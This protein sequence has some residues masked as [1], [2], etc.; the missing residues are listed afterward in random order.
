M[1]PD[2]ETMITIVWNPQDFHF[3]D[4]LPKGQKFN[5]NYYIDR[6]LQLLLETRSSRHGTGLI[7]HADNARPQ[8]ARKN[9]QIL[10]GKAL[11]T[12]AP[13]TRLTALSA[14]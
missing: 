8:T 14:V 3:V 11:R 6:I 7:I 12:G 9:F 13:S 2:R 1:I 4:A 5:E 10:P